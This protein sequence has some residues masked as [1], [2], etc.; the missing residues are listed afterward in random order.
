MFASYLNEE[1][2]I[3][4]DNKFQNMTTTFILTTNNFTLI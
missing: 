3:N 2:T 1:F 4:P